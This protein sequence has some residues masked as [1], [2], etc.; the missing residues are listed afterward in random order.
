MIETLA[1]AGLGLAAEA[2]DKA[3]AK[4]N[5]LVEAGKKFD[6]EGKNYVGDFF[7]TVDSTKDDFKTQFN[8]GK[9][10]LEETLPFLKEAEE[11][12]NKTKEDL[13]A[14]FKTTKEDLTQKAED[15]KEKFTAK[16]KETAE[17]VKSKVNNITKDAKIVEEAK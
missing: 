11:K 7:K 8:Q 13:T 14:K 6:G 4:F 15:A 16:A 3:K 9:E 17:E 10:K 1:Y 5:E 2:N 12:F